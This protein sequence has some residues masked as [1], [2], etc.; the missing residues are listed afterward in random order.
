[1]IM[2]T[3][4]AWMAGVIDLKGRLT[5]KTNR[6]RRTRQITLNVDSKEFHVVRRLCSMTGTKPEMRTT[7][8]VSD[9]LK[10]GCSEHCPEAHVHAEGFA[11]GSTRWTITGAA[12]VVVLDNIEPYISLDRGFSEAIDE[13]V[14]GLTLEGRGATA[15]LGSLSRLLG[16]GWSVRKPFLE[17][18]RDYQPGT[19]EDVLEV[20]AGPR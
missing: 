17:A 1:M 18:V 11:H 12:M 19:L 7:S 20:T 14:N 13:V 16:L 6:A 3:D 15:V 4:L 2:Q 8:P 9:Y 5:Y 10:R